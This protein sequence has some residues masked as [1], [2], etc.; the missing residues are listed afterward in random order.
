[1]TDPA[2]YARPR[3]RSRPLMSLLAALTVVL[4][5]GAARADVFL[6]NLSLSELNL[7]LGDISLAD[8]PQ[9]LTDL[10]LADLGIDLG[11]LPLQDLPIDLSTLTLSDLSFLIGGFPPFCEEGTLPGNDEVY[12]DDH[13]IITCVPESWNGGL[14]V[15]AHGYVSPGDPLG[16]P[17][18]ELLNGFAARVTTRLGFAFAA[19][20]FHKNGY[21]VEQGASDIQALVEHFR[22]NVAPGAVSRVLLVGTSEGGL[23]VTQL[24][25]Q[26]GGDYDGAWVLCAPL[27]GANRQV[28]HIGDFRAVFDVAFPTI[29]DFGVA[30]VPVT[31]AQNIEGY[32]MSIVDAF[33]ASPDLV[34][35]LGQVMGI[36]VD[37]D[38]PEAPVATAMELLRYNLEGHGDL[39]EVAGGNPY[40]NLGRIYLG[41]HDDAGLNRQVERVIPSLQARGYMRDFYQPTGRVERPMVIMHTLYDPLVPF[42]HA[43]IYRALAELAGSGGNVTVIPIPR[44]EHCD[45]TPIELLG[46]LAVLVARTGG[47]G[48]GGAA[49]VP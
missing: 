47:L 29:F 35:E 46:G 22:Q 30:G 12:P 32:E 21:A 3:R 16:L 23:I 33:E 2:P 42:E 10:S 44:Y 48:A 7:N 20:S 34:G 14:V 31:A 40:G 39:V 25:E 41:S 8:L 43:V 26:N 28:R 13:R 24:M 17:Q 5:S 19:T 11:D 9:D 45:F 27:G 36:T 6:G 37:P 15:Y 49:A 1:M 18:E 4:A 38:D